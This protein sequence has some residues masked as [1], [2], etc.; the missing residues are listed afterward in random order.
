MKLLDF[1]G[2]VSYWEIFWADH[3]SRSIGTVWKLKI[4][5]K[6]F[7]ESLIILSGYMDAIFNPQYRFSQL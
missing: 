6:E 2:L 1:G 5:T 7:L 3:E 4:V